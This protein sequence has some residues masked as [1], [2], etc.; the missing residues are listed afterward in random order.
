[1]KELIIGVIFLGNLQITSYR[2]VPEQTDSTPF[3]TATGQHTHDSGVALSRDLLSRWN[4]SVRYGDIIYIDG[5]GFK[6][7]NDC[8]NKRHT[9]AVDIWVETYKEEKAIGIRQ[10]NVWL[11]QKK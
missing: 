4:G 9:K 5:F 1:M 11:V 6:V 3:I 7:V 10:R 8:M 2:S